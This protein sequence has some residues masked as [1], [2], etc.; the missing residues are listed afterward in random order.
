VNTSTKIILG[1][2]ASLALLVP[3]LSIGGVFYLF[4]YRPDE[5]IGWVIRHELLFLV[6]NLLLMALSYG[7][8]VLYIILAVINTRLRDRKAVW[9]LLIVF[10]GFIGIPLYWYFFI[11]Q[12]GGYDA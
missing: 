6:L 3:I 2:V 1:F 4:A 10:L 9:I 5:F 8:V 12:D 7:P 11:W